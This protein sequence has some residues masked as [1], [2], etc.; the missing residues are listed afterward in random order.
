MDITHSQIAPVAPHPKPENR[1]ETSEITP[2]MGGALFGVMLGGQ[3]S[4]G[5][6]ATIALLVVLGGIGWYAAR[7]ANQYRR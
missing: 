5:T 1:K 4:L 7:R 2:A 3:F 6:P